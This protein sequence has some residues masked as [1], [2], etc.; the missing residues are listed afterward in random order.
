[1]VLKDREVGLWKPGEPR[2][3]LFCLFEQLPG[4]S[5]TPSPQCRELQDW[6]TSPQCVEQN[7]IV[8]T[9]TSLTLVPSSSPQCI[10][11]QNWL[12]LVFPVPGSESLCNSFLGQ[13]TMSRFHVD[14][15]SQIVA[16]LV[17]DWPA[18][19]LLPLTGTMLIN[20]IWR[21]S[22]TLD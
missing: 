13:N 20:S 22:I 8:L 21:T 15:A 12:N 3:G 10:H 7:R 1:M 19:Y 11:P 16:F 6:S 5:L 4:S 9:H 18:S 2:E 14:R 17:M